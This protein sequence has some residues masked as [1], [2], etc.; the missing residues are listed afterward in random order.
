M[1][2]FADSLGQ[3][4]SLRARRVVACPHMAGAVIEAFDKHLGCLTKPPDTVG[5]PIST[6]QDRCFCIGFSKLLCRKRRHRRG[7]SF[8]TSEF[9]NSIPPY[10]ATAPFSHKTTG[11]DFIEG[12]GLLTAHCVRH[13]T[14]SS[15]WRPANTDNKHEAKLPENPTNMALSGQNGM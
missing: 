4:P 3:Y 2:R 12:F 10:F 1:L 8:G 14:S 7:T 11:S 6:R 15:S 9:A 5:E 13:I